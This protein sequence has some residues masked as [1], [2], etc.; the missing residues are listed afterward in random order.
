MGQDIILC[1]SNGICVFTFIFG[2][3]P[4]CGTG[5]HPNI[6]VKTQIPLELHT[7]QHN[8]RAVL[9]LYVVSAIWRMMRI[10]LCVHFKYG[11]SS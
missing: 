3:L 11:S 7:G 4:V 2:C 5:K 9:W 6:N 10:K 1:S 8:D